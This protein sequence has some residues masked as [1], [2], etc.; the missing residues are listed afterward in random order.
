[1]VA[2]DPFM[3][4]YCN[5]IGSDF[6]TVQHHRDRASGP[7]MHDHAGNRRGVAMT[8]TGPELAD[9]IRALSISECRPALYFLAGY[10]P[11]AVEAALDEISRQAAEAA[12]VPPR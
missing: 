8:A 3:M 7:A 2:I 11:E 12:A 10:V 4:V 6:V 1:M 9:R 5:T